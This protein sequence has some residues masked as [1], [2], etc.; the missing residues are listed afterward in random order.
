L[1]LHAT[2]ADSKLWPEGC[3]IELCNYMFLNGIYCILP[4]GNAVERERGGRL[5]ERVNGGAVIPPALTIDDA[6]AL[7]AGAQGVVG[8]DTG[9]T[10]LAA[11]LGVPTLG[12]YN[13]TNPA[14]TG[15]YG[16]PQAINLG[17]IGAPPAVAD[18]I[19]AWKKLTGR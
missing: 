13:A 6:A 1:L 15:I 18:V 7:F 2:S 10:H 8:V 16:A 17:G 19:D 3:W 14:A 11:A 9:L 4:W 12:I 5:A